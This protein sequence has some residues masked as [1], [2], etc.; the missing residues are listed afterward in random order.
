MQIGP[1]EG[2]LEV[3]AHKEML[4]VLVQ[5]GKGI[6]QDQNVEKKKFIN[7]TPEDKRRCLQR[8]KT[9]SGFNLESVITF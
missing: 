5:K 7:V 3:E 2:M 9:I 1:H 4:M 6:G 8:K